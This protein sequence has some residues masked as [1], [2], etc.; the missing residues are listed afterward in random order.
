LIISVEELATELL[1]NAVSATGRW[2]GTAAVA[3]RPGRGREAEDL[4]V[5]QWF[6][7]YELTGRAPALSG[8]S[9]NST[10]RLH[11]LLSGDGA[12]AA[13]HELLAVRLTD[14][15]NEDAAQ[16]RQALVLTLTAANDPAIAKYAPV[17]AGYYDDEICEL[18]GRIGDTPMLA[19]I[20][21]EALSARMIAVLHAIE[22]HTAALTTRPALRTESD[23]ITRYR[24]HVLE[25]HGK[26]EPPDFERRRRVPIA[27][28]Y[29]PTAIYEEN[30]PERVRLTPDAESTSLT[31]WELAGRLDR[32]VL[33]GDPGGGKTTA[34]TVLMQHF[35]SNAGRQIPFLVTLR[36]FAAEDPP[37][38]SVVGFIEHELETL[39][40]CP[41]PPGL[42]DVLLLTGRAVIIFD[43]L[44]ELLDT[45]RR[46]DVSTRVERFCMEY[47][48]TPVLVTSRA[49]GYDQ[50]RLDESQ[51]TCY[52]LGGFS[53]EDVAGYS[54]KWFAL[55]EGAHPDDAA[56]F[57]TESESVPDLRSNPLL[58]SLMCIL[59]RGEGSLP[60]NRAEVYEQCANLL[61]KKWDIRRRI[62]QELRAGYLLE[63]T[64]RHLAWWLFTRP[65]TQTAVT[66][67]ELVAATVD[68]L[69]G[70]GF[71]SLHDAHDAAKGFVESTRGRMWVFSDAGSTA[72]G[73]KLYAFT[74]RT[75]LEYFAAAQL[76]YDSDT[77]EELAAKLAPYAGR[78]EWEVVGEL[79][80]QIKDRTSRDGAKRIYQVLLNE[81]QGPPQERSN[82]LQFL[83]RIL[84]SVEPSPY[85]IR[86]LTREVTNFLFA[87]NP[88]D[89]AECIPLA[90]VMGSCLSSPSIVADEIED[91]LSTMISSRN[92]D[93]HAY[94]LSLGVLLGSILSSGRYSG[95]G[96]EIVH[97]KSLENFWDERSKEF[98]HRNAE[99]IKQLSIH[100]PAM[101][102]W[103]LWEGLVTVE[104]ALGMDGGLS[105]LFMSHPLGLINYTR[106][107]YL[108]IQFR[109][110]ARYWPGPHYRPRTKNAI[111]E[112]TSI[113]QFLTA[114]P[115]LPWV[116]GSAETWPSIHW[117]KPARRTGS[118]I[119][120]DPVTYLGAVATCLITSETNP[121]AIIR[122]LRGAT[123]L[124]EFKPLY[125]YIQQRVTRTPKSPLPY[126]PVPEEF[127]Q[128]FRDW[129]ARKVNFIATASDSAAPEGF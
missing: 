58:L 40:Q 108:P 95:Q 76:A 29:V 112:M 73:E 25:Q 42:M 60:R 49:V 96:R 16:A 90:S 80:V 126:L 12:Q 48:L 117:D 83:A 97:D 68:F 106:S 85:E 104:Q 120:L 6:Q 52:R 55:D 14:G 7:T 79:A 23:F 118:K 88:N 36:N 50:A 127:R 65:E 30:H 33:L 38:R 32:T 129:A 75:F 111:E 26:L 45:A 63:P 59:Y 10:E 1:V 64:L 86:S 57:M 119:Q 122:L 56:A 47:P 43:G 94:G 78:G 51:F 92:S 72:S 70:R 66:E 39:Y 4:A 37:A 3:A 18:V 41:V 109:T 2:L 62:N 114:N 82:I 89:P 35:A 24:A 121:S 13:V 61:F 69:H 110:I 71:E 34:S 9:D 15:S 17:L 21:S 128:V 84:R 31:V 123:S 105:A 115:V 98:L 99:P 102:N 5:A 67:R 11:S 100:N 77:P 27:D 28:I 74:H 101:R 8:L 22:R 46:T 81:R 124:G 53:D 54:H 19:Q 103:A 44:D 107:P 91:I 125:P 113:G 116:T 20:R 87:N 93:T